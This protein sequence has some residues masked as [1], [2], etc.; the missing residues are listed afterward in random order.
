MKWIPLVL[1]ILLGPL[2]L[3]VV[4]SGPPN[5]FAVYAFILVLMLAGIAGWSAAS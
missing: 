3:V 4:F 1:L 2:I 5:L